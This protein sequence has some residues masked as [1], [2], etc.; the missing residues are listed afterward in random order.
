MPP[1]TFGGAIRSAASS[2]PRNARSPSARWRPDSGSTMPTMRPPSFLA[3]RVSRGSS[4]PARSRAPFDSSRIAVAL[5]SS[6]AA[7]RSAATRFPRYAA[8]SVSC[9]SAVPQT[10]RLGRRQFRAQL[11]DAILQVQLLGRA[12]AAE[13][14]RVLD[15]RVLPVVEVRRSRRPAPR[16]ARPASSP[17]AIDVANGRSISRERAQSP[18]VQRQ[19]EQ[20]ARA[21]RRRIIVRAPPPAPGSP[22]PSSAD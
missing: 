15:E 20:I 3:T 2:A 22:W 17:D 16:A 5:R 8:A 19:A 10:Q 21:R 1:G 12:R 13:E 9:G 18:V 14:G 7:R 4:S 6:P 11:G